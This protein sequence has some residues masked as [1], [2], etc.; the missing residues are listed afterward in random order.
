MLIDYSRDKWLTNKL[1]G[2][3]QRMEKKMHALNLEAT[4]P[5]KYLAKP[6]KG[7]ES[8]SVY[9][10]VDGAYVVGRMAVCGSIPYF[11]LI[12]QLE[13]YRT[14]G[15]RL[16]LLDLD[17]EIFVADGYVDAVIIK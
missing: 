10:F 14:V 11:R 4:T 1:T 13:E 6:M 3:K 16:Y 8:I 2:S 7:N 12:S 5:R 15:E 17:D 9:A